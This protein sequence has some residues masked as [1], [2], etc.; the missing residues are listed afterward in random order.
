LIK[1]WVNFK[2]MDK[3]PHDVRGGRGYVAINKNYLEKKEKRE[4]GLSYSR[5]TRPRVAI[6]DEEG[7]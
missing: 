2:K 7:K 3:G 1:P 5:S 6:F 4:P